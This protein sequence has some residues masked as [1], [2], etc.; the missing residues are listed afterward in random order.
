MSNNKKIRMSPIIAP[1]DNETI[2]L[3]QSFFQ[4]RFRITRPV[5]T[6]L[7]AKIIRCNSLNMK[8]HDNALIACGHRAPPISSPPSRRIIGSRSTRKNPDIARMIFS[9][10]GWTSSITL[11]VKIRHLVRFR[12]Y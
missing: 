10:H 3:F 5:I 6:M 11:T 8:L 9:R 4:S 12:V 2:R 1:I 7:I